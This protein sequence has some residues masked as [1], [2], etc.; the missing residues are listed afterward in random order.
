MHGS[1]SSFNTGPTGDHTHGNAT[2]GSGKDTCSSRLSW[3]ITFKS[4][5]LKQE[6]DYKELPVYRF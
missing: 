5:T 4:G 3:Q 6:P 2:G 1:T